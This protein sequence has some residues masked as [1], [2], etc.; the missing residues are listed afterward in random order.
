V[1]IRLLL[2]EMF[3]PDIAVDL[4]KRGHDV[5]AVAADPGMAGLSDDQ[6]LELAADDQ[7]CLVTENV[8]D[9]EPLRRAWNAQGRSHAGLV[10]SSPRRFPRDRQFTGAIV[11][12]LEQ[13]IVTGQVPGPD[14]VGWLS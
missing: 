8:S 14:G 6:I 3:S 4:V 10:Y 11:T 9:F 7:R 13:M 1:T 5:T 2:D 12:A